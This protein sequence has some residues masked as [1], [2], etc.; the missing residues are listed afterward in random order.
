MNTFQQE[1]KEMTE[2]I[3]FKYKWN[4]VEIHYESNPEYFYIETGVKKCN[5]GVLTK[6]ENVS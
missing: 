6:G 3:K 5:C 4:N 1:L 2:R